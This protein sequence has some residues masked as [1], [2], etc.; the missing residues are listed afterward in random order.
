[1]T[2]TCPC[3]AAGFRM[4]ISDTLIPYVRNM[5]SGTSSR[6]ISWGWRPPACCALRASVGSFPK[7]PEPEPVQAEPATGL[8]PAQPQ[9][10]IADDSATQKRRG[11]DVV[12]AD[13]DVDGDV[14]PDGEE[15]GEASVAIPACERRARAQVLASGATEPAR[16]QVVPARSPIVQPSTPG[17][18]ASTT[19][20]A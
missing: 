1:M 14:R 17:P 7:G 10:A 19:P 11:R 15:L 13:R 8:D 18:M 2:G 5:P 16:N 6:A 4:S 3:A 12:D 20:T 9:G